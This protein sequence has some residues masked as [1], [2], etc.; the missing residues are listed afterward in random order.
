M[1]DLLDELFNAEPTIQV[2]QQAVT[3]FKPAAKKGHGQIYEAVI[4]FLPN[5]EDP[6]NKSIVSKNTVFLKNPLTNAQMEVDAPSTI[7]QPDP[8]QDTFFALRNSDNPVLKE[9]SKN[10]SRRQ[11]YASLIQILD[12]KSEPALVGKIL[13]W[14]YGIKIHEKIYNEMN[15]PVGTPRNPF[16]MFIGRPFYVKVKLVSGFNNF[17]DS[18]FIDLQDPTIGA[19]KINIKNAQGQE[20]WQPI[21]KDVVASNPNVKTLVLNYLKEH[22]PSLSPY[23]FHPWTPEIT[24][25]VNTC[26]KIYTN[27]QVSM[28]AM[29]GG[30]QPLQTSPYM[31]QPAMTPQI[32]P[33]QTPAQAPPQAPAMGLQMGI[34]TDNMQQTTPGGFSASSIPGIN[35]GELD[36]ILSTGGPTTNTPPNPTANMSLDDVLSGII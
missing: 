2:E 13:V 27:P 25:F 5:P 23:E 24:E 1:A 3:E 34:N 9:N 10:F 33:Q 35:N 11:R 21:T 7:G 32:Q 14:R 29:T 26:I 15:P 28:Q 4:R 6:Q 12:C 20:V 18:Q 31:S 16:N 17:D 30:Q 8:L 22:C 19:L 36:N